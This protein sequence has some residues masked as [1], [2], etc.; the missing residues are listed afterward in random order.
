MEARL[1][2]SEPYIFFTESSINLGGQELQ[3]LQQMN[4]LGRLGYQTV[5]LCRRGSA[6]AAQAQ[7]RGLQVE[8]AGFRNA[9]DI[10]SIFQMIK[11]IKQLRPITLMCHG[12]RDALVSATAIR[13]AA[14]LGFRPPK[15]FRIKTFQQGRPLS[16]AYNYLFTKTLTPS[17]HLRQEFLVNK[18]INLFKVEVLYPGVNFAV[19]DSDSG[20]LPSPVI[21]WLDVHPGPIIAHGAVLRGEKGHQIILQAL[22]IV[23]KEFPNVRYVIA[24]D[25][26]DRSLLEQQ[27]CDLGLVDNVF[28]AGHLSSISALLKRCDLAVLPSLREPLGMFQIEAQ[29]LEVPVIASDVDG[30]PETILHQKT[31][32]LVS[33]GVVDEWASAILWALYNPVLIKELAVAGKHYVAEKFSIEKNTQS[34][35]KLFH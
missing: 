7:A 30:I 27:I 28:L 4:A 11:L 10:K 15:L 1:N 25:G 23:R 31:G 2:Q 18:W 8:I 14:L 21:H 29:Y 20:A 33:P 19:L 35:L 6:I 12:S 9:F 32:L 13:S 16:F 24:G 5:L 22:L 17:E 34:L 3:A 26:H